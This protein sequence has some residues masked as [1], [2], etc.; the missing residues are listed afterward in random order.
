MKR[1]FLFIFIFGSVSTYLF[2]QNDSANLVKY[3]PDFKFNEGIFAS[4]A[5][6][7]I[8]Q[9]I[10]KSRILS[11]L[12]FSDQY[13]YDRLLEE[14]KVYYFDNIGIKHELQT[15]NIWGYSRNGSLYIHINDDFYKITIIGSICH[16]V[17]T[18][19]T[20]S[21][22]YSDPYYY[23]YYNPYQYRYYPRTSESTEVK[24]YLFDFNTGK[25]YEYT[26]SALE[27]LLMQ[28]PE[29]YDEFMALRSKKK[30]QLKFLY[31][32]KFNERNSLYFPKN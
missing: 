21:N 14:K 18:Q 16:F 11:D 26:V 12:D 24:Q 4:F 30:K 22:S 31:I 5:Q 9:P 3:T 1:L 20:Y 28:D 25:V 2:A 19:T 29:L 15:K 7:K 32:R 23:N 17:A 10:P 8:N 27:I 6:V 13:F